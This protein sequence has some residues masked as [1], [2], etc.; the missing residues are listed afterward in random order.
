MFL[1]I[2]TG[3]L[4]GHLSPACQEFGQEF[5]GDMA[6]R[7]MKLK[8]PE[9]VGLSLSLSEY[10]QIVA[11]AMDLK[12]VNSS[13]WQYVV[14]IQYLMMSI[15]HDPILANKLRDQSAIGDLVSNI[16]GG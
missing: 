12:G 7:G 1:L 13:F 5:L 2:H 15:E 9:P 10:M 8:P 6:S 4:W 16:F 14:K 3:G 11:N